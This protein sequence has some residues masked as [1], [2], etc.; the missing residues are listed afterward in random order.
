MP[1]AP[2]PATVYRGIRVRLPDGTTRESLSCLA[3]ELGCRPQALRRYIVDHA[4]GC[5]VLGGLPDPRRCGPKSPRS[6]EYA[7]PASDLLPVVTIGYRGSDRVRVEL[8]AATEMV[9]EVVL[10]PGT[11]PEQVVADVCRI[12]PAMLEYDAAMMDAMDDPGRGRIPPGAYEAV[13]DF[14]RRYRARLINVSVALS[15]FEGVP[16]DGS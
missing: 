3:R 9:F 8:A 2:S 16:T 5:A 11:D 13:K 7:M 15:P 10:R 4:D 6:K 1:F 12:A 14:V